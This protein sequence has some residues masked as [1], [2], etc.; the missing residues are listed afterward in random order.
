MKHPYVILIIILVFLSCNS[1]D[2]GEK[3]NSLETIP[4]DVSS[5]SPSIDF[6]NL[7]DSVKHIKLA[8]ADNYLLSKI[9][10]MVILENELLIFDDMLYVFDLN[11]NFK[12]KIGTKGKGPGELIKP[13]DFEYDKKTGNVEIFD[14]NGGKLKVFTIKGDFISEMQFPFGHITRFE[15]NEDNYIALKSINNI[16]KEGRRAYGYKIQVGDFENGFAQYKP[17]YKYDDNLKINQTFTKSGNKI[18]YLQA[19]NDTIFEIDPQKGFSSSYYIDFREN[20]IPDEINKLPLFERLSVLHDN[21]TVASRVNNFYVTPKF[22][23][24]NYLYNKNKHNVLVE[25]NEIKIG[26]KIIVNDIEYSNFSHYDGNNIIV[27]IGY[28]DVISESLKKSFDTP[29]NIYDNPIVTLFYLK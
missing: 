25:N 11:G 27:S 7:I 12:R 18:F 8:T 6:S 23:Y 9:K 19:L 24:F 3:S 14:F 13:F 16:K 2:S 26:E 1:N 28:P 17:L 29:I 10:K 21:Y 22:K 4:I 5:S 15:K 20:K